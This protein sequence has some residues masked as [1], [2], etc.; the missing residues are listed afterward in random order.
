MDYDSYSLI[1]QRQLASILG[2]DRSYVTVLLAVLMDLYGAEFLEWSPD[3]IRLEIA[4]RFG[5]TVSQNTMD[6][7]QAGTVLLTTDQFFRDP[8]GFTAIANTLNGNDPSF[9][10]Y[11][12]ID[13]DQIGWAISEAALLLGDAYDPNLYQPDVAAY[14]GLILHVDGFMRPPPLAKFCKMPPASFPDELDGTDVES[15]E[16][17]HRQALSDMEQYVGLKYNELFLQLKNTP[18]MNA[19]KEQWPSTLERLHS[20]IPGHEKAVST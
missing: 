1:R 8:E 5:I 15:M 2:S 20:A 18:L 14:V 17:R 19:D 7:I 12:D 13:A 10:D 4:S 16:L 3:T 6:K 9:L 11:D